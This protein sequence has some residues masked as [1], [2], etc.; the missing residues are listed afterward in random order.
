MYFV[1]NHKLVKIKD[2]PKVDP[3]N[4]WIY[5]EKYIN[6]NDIV[7]YLDT[8]EETFK[9]LEKAENHEFRVYGNTEYAKGKKNVYFRGKILSGAD[10]TSFDMKYNQEKDVYEIRDKNK[11]YEILDIN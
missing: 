6:K 2:A 1:R 10:Y 5:N 8:D 11:V 4:L 3:Y 9:K 7:Y